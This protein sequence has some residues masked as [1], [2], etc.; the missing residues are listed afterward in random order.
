LSNGDVLL[1]GA[2]TPLSLQMA[3][4][5]PFASEDFGGFSVELKG[6]D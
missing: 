1:L 2:Y 5:A 4:L 3:Q 6:A